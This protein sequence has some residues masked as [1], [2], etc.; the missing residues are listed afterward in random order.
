[1]GSGGAGERIPQGTYGGDSNA[2][3]QRRADPRV[4]PTHS[5]K[6]SAVQ[7]QPALAAGACPR[8]GFCHLEMN[9]LIQ[10]LT[11]E[12]ARLQW[13]R[14]LPLVG[15]YASQ[16][17]F[18]TG[19]HENVSRL[20]A[21]LRFRTLLEDEI[22]TETLGAYEFEASQKWLQEVCWRRYW[23]GWLEKR[24]QVWGHWRRRVRALQRE[25][26]LAVG[27][28]AARVMSGHSGVECMDAM[29]QELLDTGYLH[30]HA[31]MWW[32]S[33][34]IHV[35]RLPWE[36]GADFFF[37]HLVDADP[38]SNT[39]SWRWV[40]GLQTAGKT[41]LVRLS[42]IEKYAPGYLRPGAVGDDLLADG[43]VTACA[44]KDSGELTP[45]PLPQYPTR[46]PRTEQPT[47]LWLHPDDLAPEIGPLSSLQPV[48]VAACLSQ[49]VYR[50]GYGL[51]P[52]RMAS[53]E[54][55]IRDGLERASVHF[56]CPAVALQTEDPSEALCE[57]AKSNALGEI[58]SFAPMA[59]PVGDLLRRLAPRLEECGVRLTLLRRSSDVAAFGAANSGFFPFWEKMKTRL[60][61]KTFSEEE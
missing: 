50:D 58:V 34:W 25:L 3:Q 13:S 53:I 12:D 18:V 44:P 6:L 29:A 7:S 52:R 48:S 35:E 38:A 32:A 20:G 51:S 49:R 43:R 10:P 54:T 27:D 36:L 14:F 41:Y 57:W 21:A 17:N 22:L 9:N 60:L 40:A 30:N 59:G 31:R 5:A 42:N 16:R 1:L 15:S 4:L 8:A 23:K 33:F 26:P 45:Q 28:R 46:L 47:G 39:L 37:R 55:V 19:G 24:P 61:Q 11:R 56:G 2:H